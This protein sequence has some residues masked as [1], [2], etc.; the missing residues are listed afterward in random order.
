[1]ERVDLE[2]VIISTRRIEELSRFYREGLRLGPF[3]KSS[4][5]L[6]QAV[7]PVYLGFDEV[8]TAAENVPG[9]IHLWFT[10]DDLDATFDRF[11][12]MGAKPHFTPTEKPW[13]ARLAAVYD[14]DGNVIGLSQRRSG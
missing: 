1:V 13:G 11:T 12:R 5:H 3:S 8:D 14:P 2:T 7:G 4:R 10:V 9:P 6:G